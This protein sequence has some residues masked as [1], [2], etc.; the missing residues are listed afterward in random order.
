MKSWRGWMLPVALLF[1][2]EASMWRSNISSDTIVPFSAVVR[3]FVQLIVDGTLFKR[4][5]ETLVSSGMGLAIGAS[6][7]LTGGILLGL[8]PRTA[9]FLRTPIELLRPIPSIALIPLSLMAFGFGT[10]MES[11]IVA[12]AIFWPVLVLSQA[13]I[14]AVDKRLLEVA[15]L[16]HLSP[17]SRTVKIVL[18]A[19][20][21]RLIM[22]L[23]LAIG[24]ALVVAVTVEITANPQ[25]LGYGLIVAQQALRPGEMLAMLLWVGTLGWALNALL[26]RA[27]RQLLKKLGDAL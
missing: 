3:S 24:L 21:P 6:I 2:W 13:A 23:R 1:F 26:V 9:T 20:T 8:A 14:A 15:H 4:T 22:T 11:A 25:G 27:E 5:W 17:L 10:S 19:A 12:F 16:L 18:P 7:G